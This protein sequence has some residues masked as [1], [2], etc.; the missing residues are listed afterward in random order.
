MVKCNLWLHIIKTWRF[1]PIASHVLN[2]IK[3]LSNRLTTKLISYFLLLRKIQRTFS[4]AFIFH[5]VFDR[6]HLTCHDTLV[7]KARTS[8][9]WRGGHSSLP[10][11]SIRSCFISLEF[12]NANS[13]WLIALFVSRQEARR[14]STRIDLCESEIEARIRTHVK[15]NFFPPF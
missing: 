4:P 14:P 15:W 8:K 1:I 10:R 3:A 11:I 12:L 2:N 5:F 9:G 6:G 13:S 7:D